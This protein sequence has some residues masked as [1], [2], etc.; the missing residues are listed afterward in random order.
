MARNPKTTAVHAGASIE[1]SKAKAISPPLHMASAS[2]F[3]RA[4]D[5]DR[6]LDG[7]DFVY[8]RNRSQNAELLEEAIAALE[9]AE[10]CASFATGMAALRAVLDAQEL[11]R[12]DRVVM[13][14]DGYGTTRALFKSF[15]APRAIELHALALADAGAVEKILELRPKFVL[16]ESIT[17]PLISVSDIRALS[18]ACHDVGAVFAVDA[19]FA[20]P[21]LQQ[22]AALGADYSIHSTTK[23]INGHGDAMGGAVSGRRDRIQ[24]LKAARVLAGSVL[25]PF[26]AWLTLRGLRTLPIRMK[27]H[28]AHAERITKRLADSQMLERVLYPGLASH[29]THN[30][31]RQVLDGG[32]GGMLAFKIRRAARAEAFRF[33][34]SL[35]LAKPAP[36]LGDVAT[37]VMHAATA[38]ARRL[39]QQ[40]RDAAGI[41]ENLI[42]VSVGLE[43][44]DD[45]ADD[46]LNALAKA[47]ERGR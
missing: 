17:N 39:T 23:W 42:R 20:S 31:A 4:D 3:E 32:F 22:P 2:Y 25:G 8:A 36:S 19:S 41:G 10:E 21:I 27:A 34:E 13:P 45:I 11:S 1:G 12:G 38:S 24:P 14:W 15:L 6:S 33:L 30:V 9:E 5:L 46:L 44:P 37:L 26:E 40:E 43:D 35:R 18:R 7:A 29:P 47:M 16:A 28:C